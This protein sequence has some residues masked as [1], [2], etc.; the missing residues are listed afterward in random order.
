M[1]RET[2][3][4]W[5]HHSLWD[6]DSAAL[7]ASLS[8]SMPLPRSCSSR[9]LTS[10]GSTL[11]LRTSRVPCLTALCPAPAGSVGAGRA[12]GSQWWG[13]GRG[14]LGDTHPPQWLHQ[15]KHAPLL[16]A[17]W[18]LFDSQAFTGQQHVLSEGEYPTLGAMGC[19]SS[20][21]IRSLK[22]VPVVS[23][24]PTSL[25]QKPSEASLFPAAFV[26][27]PQS[28]SIHMGAGLPQLS[29]FTPSSLPPPAVLLRALHL[30]A[31]PGVF[32]G[33]GDRVE[34]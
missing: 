3:L 34:Q 7:T 15:L 18:I 11:P 4:S 27:Q 33:E 9:S 26:L 24:H 6:S 1:G 12:L 13:I 25:R 23:V 32:R 21:T 5:C 19:L 30:P 2:H 20:T 14:V 28:P 10:W 8:L 29:P 22:K 31:W 16:L 17:S